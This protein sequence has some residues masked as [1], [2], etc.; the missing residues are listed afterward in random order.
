MRRRMAEKICNCCC[1][2]CAVGIVNAEDALCEIAGRLDPSRR[3]SASCSAKLASSSG[4]RP[5]SK[6]DC[7]RAMAVERPSRISRGVRPGGMGWPVPHVTGVAIACHPF[8]LYFTLI[9]R[10][11]ALRKAVKLVYWFVGSLIFAA[12][13]RFRVGRCEALSGFLRARLSLLASFARRCARC[14]RP[15]DR[16]HIAVQ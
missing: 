11:C 1:A 5:E 12:T 8:S 6:A 4:R 7:A 15:Q 16:G 13:G 2:D 3:Q 9:F 14:R 10:A